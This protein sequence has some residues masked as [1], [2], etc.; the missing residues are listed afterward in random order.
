MK[1]KHSGVNI[2]KS[3]HLCEATKR[4]KSIVLSSQT[5]RAVDNNDFNDNNSANYYY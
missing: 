5:G 1:R 2:I 4:Q 3:H